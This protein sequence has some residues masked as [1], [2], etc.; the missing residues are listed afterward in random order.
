MLVLRRKLDETI[1]VN[2]PAGDL[3]IVLIE[4]GLGHSK[5]GIAAPRDW[6]I[7]RGELL[8]S[9]KRAHKERKRAA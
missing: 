8:E 9:D 1:V 7:R 3:E 4:T 2:T 6:K 5:I